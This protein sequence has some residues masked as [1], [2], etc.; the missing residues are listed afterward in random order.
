MG[1]G[2]G[3]S[4]AGWLWQGTFREVEIKMPP[5]LWLTEGLTGAGRFTS[6][7]AGKL[8][9]ALGRRPHFLA[10]LGPLFRAT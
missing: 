8:V 9:L 1:Q 2:I 7:M 6:R 10:S 3:K 5:R 4:V